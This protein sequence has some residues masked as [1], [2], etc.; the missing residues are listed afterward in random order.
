[1]V[2]A[3]S[4]LICLLERIVNP[5]IPKSQCSF[6]S[7]RSTTD[8]V[9]IACLVQ[10]KCLEQRWDLYMA[11]F[12]LTKAFGTVN[13]DLLWNML[14]KLRC[15]PIFSAILQPPHSGACACVTVAS[16]ESAVSLL[17]SE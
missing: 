2:L 5:V 14:F 6:H 7:E 12:D 3:K 4:K 13:Y 17:M 9:F 10:E 15:P 11:F 8:V 16:A 1:M